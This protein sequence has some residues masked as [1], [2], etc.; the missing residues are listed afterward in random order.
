ML[1]YPIE[2]T[3]SIS[4][5]YTPVS[6]DGDTTTTRPA[7]GLYNW[8]ET[9]V[10]SLDVSSG[11]KRTDA[12]GTVELT[13]SGIDKDSETVTVYYRIMNNPGYELPATGGPGTRLFTI[14]GSILILGSGALLW[15]R[16]RLI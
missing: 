15:R 16:R 6:P 2:V 11:V 5:S 4:D 7:T 13:H 12:G 9:A 8:V 14:L 1:T 10:L 3:F